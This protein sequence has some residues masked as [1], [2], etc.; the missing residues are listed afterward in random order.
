MSEKSIH[1]YEG[2]HIG[3]AKSTVNQCLGRTPTYSHITDW[4]VDFFPEEIL[5]ISKQTENGSAME[6]VAISLDI[7][8][9]PE[10]I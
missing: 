9:Y 4:G 6:N 3:Q 7:P 2:D 8:T 5:E 10:Q 1:L